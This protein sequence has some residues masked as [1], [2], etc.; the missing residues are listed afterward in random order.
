MV[1]SKPFDGSWRIDQRRR[2][3][4]SPPF[5]VSAGFCRGR[6]AGGKEK[7]R[8]EK[9]VRTI[10]LSKREEGRHSLPNDDVLV[11]HVFGLAHD[12]LTFDVCRIGRC[13]YSQYDVA[14]GQLCIEVGSKRDVVLDLGFADLLD[15]GMDLER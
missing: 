2:G 12:H 3:E 8:V 6:R 7:G 4:M 13:G 9:R 1:D 14:A 11:W 10:I 5:L 15:D